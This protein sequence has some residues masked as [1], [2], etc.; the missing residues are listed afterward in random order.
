M[1]SSGVDLWQNRPSVISVQDHEIVCE[2]DTGAVI[3]ALSA[4]YLSGT[5]RVA[6]AAICA[7]RAQRLTRACLNLQFDSSVVTTGLTYE[8]EIRRSTDCEGSFAI[9]A[10]I[11]FP[12][13]NVFTHQCFCFDLE[14]TVL[15]D[16][17][18]LWKPTGRISG[19]SISDFFHRMLIHAELR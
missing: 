4:R 2:D 15:L 10:D 18:D 8:L 7:P 13:S 6:D 3:T 12:I 5:M 1:S 14:P 16:K 17:C 19:G 9:V 11:E